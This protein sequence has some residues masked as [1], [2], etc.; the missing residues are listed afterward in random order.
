MDS[1]EVSPL[2]GQEIIQAMGYDGFSIQ[3]PENYKKYLAVAKY[4]A[5]YEDGTQ[6]AK[7]V[8]RA[9]PLQ[10]KAN[11]LFEYVSLRKDLDEVR[12][13]IGELPESIG[14]ESEE[15]QSQRTEYGEQENRLLNELAWYE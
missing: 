10:D 1:F 3:T 15:V 2:I 8:T 14:E 11:K 7:M 12:Q 13:K 4:L 9:T 6:I 5:R